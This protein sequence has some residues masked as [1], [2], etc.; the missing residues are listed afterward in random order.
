MFNSF[1]IIKNVIQQFQLS[2][3]IVFS[4]VALAGNA[5]LLMY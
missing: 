3:K 4:E 2:K 5:M 1:H